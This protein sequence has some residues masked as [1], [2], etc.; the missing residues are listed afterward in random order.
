MAMQ[1]ADEVMK[2][3]MPN[4]EVVTELNCR[5][6]LLPF[7]IVGFDRWIRYPMIAIRCDMMGWD[8]T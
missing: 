3:W 6:T 7:L 5:R 2:S 8:G 4:T 1:M